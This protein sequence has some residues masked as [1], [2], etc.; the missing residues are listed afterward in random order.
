[1]GFFIGRR[2]FFVHRRFQARFIAIFSAFAVSAAVAAAVATR[3]TVDGALRDAMFRAHFS[4]RSIGAIVLPELLKVNALVAGVAF[5]ASVVMAALLFRWSAARLD[6][7][8]SRLAQWER[9]LAGADALDAPLALDNPHHWTADLERAVLATDEALR[10]RYLPMA[11]RA[12][13]LADTARQLQTD[14]VCG[15][16]GQVV[17]D[18]SLIRDEIGALDQDCSSFQG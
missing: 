11:A 15:H 3:F 14:L 6:D 9:R 17:T 5:L 12:T 13:R 10:A 16:P 18:L 4:A 1:M 7:I 2:R 8:C